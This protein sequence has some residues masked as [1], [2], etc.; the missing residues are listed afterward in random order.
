MH[1]W[2]GQVERRPGL[3]GLLGQL[4]PIRVEEGAEHLDTLY[5]HERFGARRQIDRQRISL[6]TNLPC[7]ELCR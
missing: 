5:L 3:P 4:S 6:H 2:K 7:V 1:L